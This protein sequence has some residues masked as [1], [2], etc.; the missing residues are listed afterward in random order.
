MHRIAAAVRDGK[1][2][3]QVQAMKPTADYDEKWGGGFLKPEQFTAIVYTSV[4][5]SR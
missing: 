5:K 4:T 1:T 3:A 2:L